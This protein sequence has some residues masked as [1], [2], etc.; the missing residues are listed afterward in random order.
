MTDKMFKRVILKITQRHSDER[1]LLNASKF[2]FCACYSM[3]FQCMKLTDHVTNFNNMSTAVVFLG[4][5]KAFDTTW[6]SGLLYKLSKLQFSTSL[7]KL[8]ISFL[9]SRKVGGLVEGDMS[10]QREIQ[11]RV[12]Q[13]S[14][15]SP[16]LY[17]LYILYRP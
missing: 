9:L 13:G 16:A 15:L 10:T 5:E 3:A 12:P 17:S 11:A 6:Q 14:I 7:I 8:I 4:T 2:G 1:N